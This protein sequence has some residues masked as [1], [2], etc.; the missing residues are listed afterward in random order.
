[1]VALLPKLLMVLGSYLL[2]FLLRNY[3]PFSFTSPFNWGLV[4]GSSGLFFLQGIYIFDLPQWPFRVMGSSIPELANSIQGTAALNPF[5]ASVLIPFVL[6]AILLGHRHWKWFAIGTSLG[7][8]GCLT[9]HA[10]ISPVVWTMP[11]LELSRAFLG[12][13]AFCCLGLACLASKKS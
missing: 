13:N 2:A 4:L 7:V 9:V 5:L 1:M 10:I 8:A 3:F 12:V 11:S 6:V